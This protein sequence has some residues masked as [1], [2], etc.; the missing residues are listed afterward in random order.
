MAGAGFFTGEPH[1]AAWEWLRHEAEFD[2]AMLQEAI[3]PSDLGGSFASVLFQSRFPAQNL[4]W[5]NCTLVRDQEF[6]PLQ[7]KH[8]EMLGEA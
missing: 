3:P 2:V 6:K 5:G 8:A 7:V 1:A 4:G